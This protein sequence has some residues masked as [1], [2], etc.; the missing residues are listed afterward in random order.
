MHDRVGFD[1]SQTKMIIK[2]VIT[3]ILVNSDHHLSRVEVCR[4]D[5]L[6]YWTGQFVPPLTAKTT[7]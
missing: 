3:S 7:N 5:T 2:S 1:K 6:T 4:V